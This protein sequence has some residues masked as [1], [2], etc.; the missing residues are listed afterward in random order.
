MSCVMCALYT[1]YGSF[2][3]ISK[4]KMLVVEK[5]VNMFTRLCEKNLKL[6]KKLRRDYR[7]KWLQQN[8]M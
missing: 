6:L 2:V 4:S 7:D 1:Y 8:I 3:F 5:N